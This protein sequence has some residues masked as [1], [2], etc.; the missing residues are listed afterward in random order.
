M[1][2]LKAT[3][4]KIDKKGTYVVVNL[5]DVETPNLVHDNVSINKFDKNGTVFPN[6][7]NLEKGQTIEGES[8]QSSTGKWYVYPPKPQG[9]ANRGSGAMTKVMERKESSI[10]KSMDRKEEGIMT[11]STMR[12][13]VLIALAELGNNQDHLNYASRILHWRKWLLDNWNIE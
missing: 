8:W 6:F 7:D 12:D 9:G 5:K 11:S 3:I 13:A 2:Y 4:E 1:A 10:S